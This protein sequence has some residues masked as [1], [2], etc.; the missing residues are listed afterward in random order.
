MSDVGRGPAGLVARILTHSVVDGPGNRGVVFLQGCNFSCLYCHNPET[1]TACS[2]CGRCVSGCPGGALERVDGR[3]QWA[4]D[5][6]QRC[7]RCLE[8]CPHHSQPRAKVMTPKEVAEALFP[9]FPFISGL[10]ISGGEPSVQADFAAAVARE[11]RAA[12]VAAGAAA[13]TDRRFDIILNTNASM[14]E[15]VRERLLAPGVCD[16]AIVDVK[17][18]DPDI[19]R[20]LTGTGNAAV[21]AN[22]AELARRGHLVEVRTVVAPG[23]T[24][25]TSGEIPRIAA[26]LAGLDP[27]IPY[28]LIRFRPLGVRGAAAG[29]ALP[30]DAEMDHLVAAAR[31]AGLRRVSRSL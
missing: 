21:I 26:F 24:D 12:W 1:W 27:S 18:F 15:E 16:G 17:A 13:M 22:V 30:G 7:D 4:E 6:C 8:V 19:H 5:L 25:G 3:V 31:S 28:R 23:F 20:R 14:P 29:W 9:A 2:S 11:V 10:T